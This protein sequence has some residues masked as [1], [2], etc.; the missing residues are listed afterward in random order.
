MALDRFAPRHGSVWGEGNGPQHVRQ[1]LAAK[2]KN[3]FA[4]FD[5]KHEGEVVE[6][7][8]YW[9]RGK[10]DVPDQLFD[11]QFALNDRDM[12][13][14]RSRDSNGNWWQNSKHSSEYRAAS[15]MGFGFGKGK[16]KR[17]GN[18][19]GKA[20]ADGG[21]DGGIHGGTDGGGTGVAPAVGGSKAQQ[22]LER[23]KPHEWPFV[24]GV[25]YLQKDGAW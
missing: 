11:L 4:S 19:K 16:G 2:F 22:V 17:K 6:L 18:D 15:K 10:G 24:S 25:L 7:E 20:P 1:P 13:L 23:R 9:K 5:E 12:Q 14:C 21:T 3:G 8:G